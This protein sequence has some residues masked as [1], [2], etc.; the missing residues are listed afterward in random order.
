MLT[1]YLKLLHSAAKLML[2]QVKNPLVEPNSVFDDAAQSTA[3]LLCVM[4]GV[5]STFYG[6][7]DNSVSLLCL[8]VQEQKTTEHLFFTVCIGIY[9]FSCSW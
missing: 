5:S 1:H 2:N 6:L 4:L 9:L 7:F 3:L 8:W